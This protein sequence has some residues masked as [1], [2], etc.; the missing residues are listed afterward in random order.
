[1]T[2][3]TPREVE[4]NQTINLPVAFEA[5]VDLRIREMAGWTEAERSI[6][7]LPGL[8]RGEAHPMPN[9]WRELLGFGDALM[10]RPKPDGPKGKAEVVFAA[11]ARGLARLAYE[12]G[13]VTLFGVHFCTAPHDGCP[14]DWTPRAPLDVAATMAEFHRILDDYEA[15]PSSADENWAEAA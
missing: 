3:R 15:L 14:K 2:G 4:V 10:Y 11:Y 9:G 8:V 12:P 7:A 1:M 13:G 5:A 6:I